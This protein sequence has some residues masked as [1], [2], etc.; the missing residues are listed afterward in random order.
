MKKLLLLLL[1]SLT[2]CTHWL[3]DTETRIQME[4]LT[5]KEICDLSIGENIIVPGCLKSGEIS[6]FH[7]NDWVGTFSFTIYIEGLP[8]DLGEHKLKGGTITAQISEN[9]LAIR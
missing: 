5:E 3:I 9:S 2:S 1:S 8:K 4:N 6:K 7:E